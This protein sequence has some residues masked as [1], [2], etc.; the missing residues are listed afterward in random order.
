MQAEL[1]PAMLILLVEDEILLADGIRDMLR[2]AGHT[3]EVVHD[4]AAGLER[5]QD[6]RVDLIV[7]DRLLPKLD[8]L[9][10]CRR[11]RRARPFVPI[12]MLTALGSE[13][14]KVDGLSIG[15]DDYVVK[16]FG[17]R[18]LLAR[19]QAVARRAST[20]EREAISIDGCELDLGRGSATRGDTKMELTAREV[21]I[22]RWLYTH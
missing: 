8:G 20:V 16:P 17:A 7:L 6:P 10:V 11:L 14:D 1:D 2:A 3:V 21:E 12:V 13:D 18:E 5:A 19:V 9:E 4:G 22:L 15:A